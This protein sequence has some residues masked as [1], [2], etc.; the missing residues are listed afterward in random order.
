MLKSDSFF[1]MYYQFQILK[2]YTVMNG[3]IVNSM[4][5]MVN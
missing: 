2:N 4:R 3:Q 5:Q 1:V